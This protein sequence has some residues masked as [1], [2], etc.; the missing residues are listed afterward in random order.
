M[1]FE[2][3]IICVVEILLYKQPVRLL[4]D[5][6]RLKRLQINHIFFSLSVLA[7]SICAACSQFVMTGVILSSSVA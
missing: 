2:H 7:G 1:F 4:R 3:E 5:I 6:V